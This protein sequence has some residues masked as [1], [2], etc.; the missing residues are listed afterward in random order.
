MRYH[1]GRGLGLHLG[2]L[3]NLPVSQLAPFSGLILTIAA[4]ILAA[5][6]I[7]FLDLVIIPKFYSHR[8]LRNLTDGQRRSFVNHHI[9]AGSKILLIFVTAYPLLAILIG[10]GTP[11]TPFSPG[12]AT[13]L[14]DVLIVSSQI[15]TIMYI[16]E[17]FYRDKISPI[18]FA[19]HVSAIVI[20]QSAISLTINFD[21][22]SDAIY[23][24]ILCLIWG[25]FIP[26]QIPNKT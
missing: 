18:S 12:S 13:T 26:L 20:A 25:T 14:G 22:E 5:I 3:V 24:F 23:E 7:Y 21:H 8:V 11:H 10:Y 19:H 2:E 17:L 1:S 9:A 6:R 4:C 15:F 16:F